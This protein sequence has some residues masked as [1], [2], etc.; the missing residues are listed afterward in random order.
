MKIK[1]DLLPSWYRE[2]KFLPDQNWE[3]RR[4][5]LSFLLRCFQ[6]ALFMLPVKKNRVMIYT[7]ERKGFSCNPKY[8]AAGLKEMYGDQLELIWVTSYPETCEEIRAMGI[9]VAKTNSK[10]HVGKYMRTRVYVT[11]DGF[12][13]WA[14]HR[15]SQIWINVWHGGMNYKRIG[16][17][18]LE[19]MSRIGFRLYQLE[20][21][22]PDIYLA[23]SEYF[24]RDTARSF[25]FPEQ[26]FRGTGMPRNDLFFEKRDEIKQ[27]ITSYYDV[28]PERRIVMYAPTFRCNMENSTYGLN[29]D[30]LVHALEERFGGEWTVF[31]RNHNFVRSDLAIT[32]DVTDVSDYEDMQELLY[33]A[34]VLISDYSSCMWDFCLTNRPCFVYASDRG[35]YTTEDRTL[36]IPMEEWPYPVACTNEELIRCI[37]SFD[38]EEYERRVK[39]HLADMGSYDKGDASV[40]AAELI[41]S[42]CLKAK[43]K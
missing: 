25:S 30:E 20:N 43:G 8:V 24:K 37:Q 7:H 15:P 10:I 34:D 33:V 26:I 16:Y 5:R 12:P 41:G 19:P 40:K 17:Q 29:F 22:S 35:K 6:R 21:R 36:G 28:H 9:P 18:H 2:K 42:Y 11:N 4:R 31:F 3:K 13:A 1:K 27:K 38:E 32:D 39:K 14:L 23:G